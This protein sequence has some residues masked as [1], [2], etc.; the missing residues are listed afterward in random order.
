M[1]Q[2]VISSGVVIGENHEVISLMGDLI[3]TLIDE[4]LSQEGKQG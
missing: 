1:R 2:S 4:E 3:K